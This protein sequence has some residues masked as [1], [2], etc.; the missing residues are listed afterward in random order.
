V[1]RKKIDASRFRSPPL[2]KAAL[3]VVLSWSTAPP[4][5]QARD[6][7]DQNRHQ[8]P[9]WICRETDL[10]ARRLA[11]DLAVSP[12]LDVACRLADGLLI[13][14]LMWFAGARGPILIPEPKVSPRV[15]LR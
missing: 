1:I 4:K 15:P 2:A 10:V 13:D 3:A 7:A 8:Q 9:S 6:A 11:L 5:P 14:P 12:Q